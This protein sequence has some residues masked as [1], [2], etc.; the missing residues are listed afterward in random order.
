M[1]GMATLVALSACGGVQLGSRAT[2][3]PRATSALPARAVGNANLDAADF[4]RK[5]GMLA[6]G[7]PLPFTGSV[8]FLAAAHDDSTHAVIALSLAAGELKFS[9]DGDGYRADYRV[10]LA[11][12]RGGA[13]AARVDVVEP[14]RVATLRET[15]R[16]DESVM[17]QQ[18]LTVSPG[19]YTLSVTVR[20]EGSGLAASQD[21]TVSVPSFADGAIAS[22][23]AY[24]DVAARRSRD[25]LP[26]IVVSP[27]AA[28]TVGVDSAI[29]FYVETYGSQSPAQL[30]VDARVDGQTMWSDSVAVTRGDGVA[31]A[32]VHVP[33]A[34]IGIGAAA[35]QVWQVG[36]KDT[37]RVPIFVGLGD[38]LPPTTYQDVLSYLRFFTTPERLAQLQ[39]L[40]PA[41]RADGWSAFSRET[42]PVPATAENEALTDYLMRL[43]RANERFLGEETAGWRTD[44]G[45]VLLLLGEPDQ[46]LD[47]TQPNDLSQRG[48]SQSWEYRALGYSVDFVFVAGTSQWRLASA[49]E[50]QLRAAARRRVNP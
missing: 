44:R 34:R 38:E 47:Q 49:T 39:A 33:V 20:D 41:Q 26:H 11:L 13:A 16:T 12:S 9:R 22:P 21:L 17:F 46:I 27:R 10:T 31:T 23:M 48:R 1:I 43:R 19:S 25:S 37:L 15:R 2:P 6:Q 42:D 24:Y 50:A 35:L 29:T 40:A 4:Y 18:L 7:A 5:L 32:L 36:G 45:M 14:V 28:A 30:M 3:T 8:A